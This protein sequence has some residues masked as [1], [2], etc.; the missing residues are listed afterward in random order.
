M[1]NLFILLS[2]FLSV[3]AV[4]EDR[5]Y[6]TI[7]QEPIQALSPSEKDYGIDKDSIKDLLW[8]R[9]QTDNFTILSID[10]AQGRELF[11]NIE[12]IK[13]ECLNRYGFK[14]TVLSK[15]CRIM[16]TP[17]K[18][19]FKR[20]FGLQSPRIEFRG[21]VVAVWLDSENSEEFN[22]S[23]KEVITEVCLRDLNS[24]SSFVVSKGMSKLNTSVNNVK[25]IIGRVSETQPGTDFIKVTEKD[26]QKM[27]QENKDKFDTESLVFCLMLKKEFGESKFLEYFFDKNEKI[28]GFD[29]KSLNSSYNRYYRDI[30][31]E[32]KKNNIPNS[33][34]NIGRE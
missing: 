34:L 17:S 2:L 31:N 6:S 29:S 14:N 8:N 15:D 4:A 3:C 30:F 24:K 18:E 5:N 23:V 28:Y 20:L 22:N 21:D 25:S 26:Y 7:D 12:D 10:N 32:L 27:N 13:K 1:K 11:K 33:Y 16:L 19:L 9:Y